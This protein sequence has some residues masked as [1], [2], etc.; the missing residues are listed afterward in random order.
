MQHNCCVFL[1][2]QVRP[3]SVSLPAVGQDAEWQVTSP[4][5]AAV[6]GHHWEARP[7]A[8]LVVG[9]S[10]YLHRSGASPALGVGARGS[11]SRGAASQPGNSHGHPAVPPLESG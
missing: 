8:Q 2:W 1:S 11:S 6:A 3:Q 10:R 9:R 7:P 5:R 4:K